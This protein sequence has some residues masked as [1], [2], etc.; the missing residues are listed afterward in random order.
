M[1]QL[2]ATVIGT[3][4]DDVRVAANAE[5]A[6]AVLATDEVSVIVS[7]VELPGMGGLEFCERVAA[8][9]PDIPVIIVT[10]FPSFDT[11]IASLRLGAA[12]FIVKPFKPA[13]LLHRVRQAVQARSLREEVKRLRRQLGEVESIG[14][15]LGESP[16][17]RRLK[18]LIAQVARSRAS[19]LIMG[20]SGTGKELVARALHDLGPRAS[21]PFIAINSSAVPGPLIESELFGHA[22]GAFTDARTE[23]VGLFVR[24]HKGTLFL[25]E[26]GELPLALQP[27]LL[28][29]LEE[30]CVRPVG[31]TR[32]I[33]FDVRI[34]AATN[35]DLETAV[36]EGRFREDLYFRLNVINVEL[37]RLC[38]RGR[39]ILL[40]A[41]HFLD[42]LSEAEGKN[43][44][45]F[46]P[47]VAEKLLDYPWPGN[48]RELRNC[49]ERA[50]TLATHEDI[51]VEDLP[52]KLRDS[53]ARSVIVAGHTPSELG[54]LDDMERRYIKQVMT[55]V[56]GNKTHAARILGINR[57]RLYRKLDR[58]GIS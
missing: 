44:R 55:V 30:R 54:T 13:E 22:R 5:E 38:E 56:G 15:M 23:R 4:C 39:D 7:D 43:V 52:A 11:A 8:N 27:K 49:I 1:A 53:S 36:A 20:E 50:V 6:F 58:H 21:E 47:T 45:G 48:V 41:Q 37:P 51:L 16:P 18:A 34:I 29:A 26:I 35:R 3:F 24:A 14:A 33:P 25:D 10:A 19:A 2:I 17:M 28:R 9:R 46:T 32:E 42:E 31:G 40:L 57:K 12:D